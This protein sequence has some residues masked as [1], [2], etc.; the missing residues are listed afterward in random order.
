MDMDVGVLGLTFSKPVDVS[1]FKPTVTFQNTASNPTAS[2]TPEIQVQTTAD[3]RFVTI[4]VVSNDLDVIKSTANLYTSL[5]NSYL[6]FSTGGGVGASG[7]IVMP[8]GT[9]QAV[10]VTDYIA[11]LT[12]PLITSI[13][14]FDLNSGTFDMVTNEAINPSSVVATRITVQNAQSNPGSAYTL[15]GGTASLLDNPRKVRVQMSIGDLAELKIL[16][17]IANGT[18]S[19]FISLA[20]GAVQDTNA[21]PSIGATLQAGAFVSDTTPVRLACFDLD[22]NFGAVELAFNDVVLQSSLKTNQLMFQKSQSSAAGSFQLPSLMVTDGLST[23]IEV[24]LPQDML[25]NMKIDS[26]FATSLSNTYISAPQGFVVD[27]YNF[28]AFEVASSNAIQVCN[29]I[30]DTTS[31]IAKAFYLDLDQG[32][33]VVTFSEPILPSSL[34]SGNMSLQN[35]DG[36]SMLPSLSGGRVVATSNTSIYGIKLSAAD[37]TNIHNDQTIGSSDPTQ[38]V[39]NILSGAVTDYNSNPVIATQLTAQSITQDSSPP[40]VSG[41]TLDIGAK[42][43]IITFSEPVNIASQATFVGSITIANSP[44]NPLVSLSSTNTPNSIQFQMPYTDTVVLTLP[45]DLIQSID[46]NPAIAN[47]VGDLHLSFTDTNSVSDLTGASMGAVYT[48]ATG[49]GKCAFKM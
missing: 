33:I 27:I 18:S 11:D 3:S 15:V 35:A 20:Q 2:V 32:Q 17:T 31:P 14:M 37:L 25:S 22:L 42:Q 10:Q 49:I 19:T 7:G 39:L 48:Q 38:T 8:I 23:M 16:P 29:L 30:P 24:Q 41:F 45:D 36:S 43:I 4:V 9:S 28:P 44:T 46:S 13:S 21:N 47:S 12:R 26:S 34:Q 1:T 40:T 5:A 6:S